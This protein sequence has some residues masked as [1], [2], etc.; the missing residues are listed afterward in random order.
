MQATIKLKN[1]ISWENIKK[2]ALTQVQH[3][4]TFL[5]WTKLLLPLTPMS[6]TDGI[7][8]DLLAN[9]AVSIPG[10]E[11]SA[12]P[13]KLRMAIDYALQELAKCAKPATRRSPAEPADPIQ[14]IVQKLRAYAQVERDTV[15]DAELARIKKRRGRRGGRRGSVVCS[16]PKKNDVPEGWQPKS[17]PKSDEM[18]QHLKQ[19][20]SK[21]ILLHDANDFTLDTIVDCM[22]E[23]E[24]EPDVTIIKEGDPGD[25]LY[26]LTKGWIQVYKFLQNETKDSEGKSAK[27]SEEKEGGG[28]GGRGGKDTLIAR[29]EEGTMFGELAL[30]YDAPRSATCKAGDD[31]CNCWAIDRVTFR[32][33]VRNSV[34]SRRKAYTEA[35]AKVPILQT[36]TPYE[37]TRLADCIEEEKFQENQVILQEGD[38]GDH[39]YIVLEGEVKVTKLGFDTN[40]GIEAPIEVCDRLFNGAYFGE[41]ALI[42]NVP[43][44]ATVTAVQT[45]RT[46]RIDR[47]VF[48]RMMGKLGDILGRN[49]ELYAKYEEQYVS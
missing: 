35:L 40:T 4:Y 29:M 33:V 32:Q 49:M 47:E 3:T 5:F 1:L 16:A 10:V 20:V 42:M 21:S 22:F 19:M 13:E 48:E 12:V 39:F 26:L 37:R 6:N 41:I 31:G 34:T 7:T 46:A 9:L 43:R 23:R 11:G 25:N 2:G 28:V 30:M 15:S 38:T 8:K 36:I 45:T 17:V 24:F 14:F 44:T 18:R 27:N